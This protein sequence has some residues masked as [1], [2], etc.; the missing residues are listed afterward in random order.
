MARVMNAPKITSPIII[1]SDESSK[2]DT[3]KGVRSEFVANTNVEGEIQQ[4]IE[5]VGSQSH[6]HIFGN[7]SR[8][9]HFLIC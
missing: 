9:F 4:S 1:P 7:I 6:H 2:S 3:C 8:P 5:E